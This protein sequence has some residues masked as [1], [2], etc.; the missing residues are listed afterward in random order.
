MLWLQGKPTLSGL[1]NLGS[2][3]A[4]S[5]LDLAKA[6]FA[7]ANRTCAIEFIDMPMELSAGYQYFTQADMSKLRAVGYD[8][9]MTTLEAGIADYVSNFLTKDDPYL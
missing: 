3:Q 8:K 6:M 1:L 4:R 9:P 7:A 2:G 5:W